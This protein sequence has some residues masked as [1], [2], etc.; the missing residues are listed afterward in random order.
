M[1]TSGPTDPSTGKPTSG[2]TYPPTGMP[3][4]TGSAPAPVYGGHW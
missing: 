3:T 1:P 4:A 2:A